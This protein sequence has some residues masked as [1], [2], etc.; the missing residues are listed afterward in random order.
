MCLRSEVLGGGGS[1]ATISPDCLK[2]IA[3]SRQRV[4]AIM[5]EMKHC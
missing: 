3:I 5:V 1:T 4:G 2:Q